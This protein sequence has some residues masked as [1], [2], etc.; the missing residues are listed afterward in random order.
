MRASC[1]DITDQLKTKCDQDGDDPIP[2]SPEP[3]CAVYVEG[4]SNLSAAFQL[5]TFHGTPVVIGP[6]DSVTNKTSLIPRIQLIAPVDLPQGTTWKNTFSKE[7]KW[8]AIECS[9]DPVVHS[10]RP[11]V[12]RGIYHQ[13]T[14][15]ISK[16]G[17]FEDSLHRPYYM[18]PP[19]GPEMGI[20]PNKDF[21]LTT[22]S[23]KAIQYFFMDFFAG[24]ARLDNFGFTF[25]PDNPEYKYATADLMQFI[26]LSNLTGCPGGTTKKMHCA[27]DNVAEAMS[28]AIRDT[29]PS[30]NLATTT[31]KAMSD[32]THISIHWQWII[33]PVLVWLLGLV[34]LLGT[35][36]KTRKAM[37]PT[38]KNETMPLLSLYR[39]GQNEKPLDDQVLETERVMLYQ[40]EGKMVLSG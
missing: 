27:M 39:D 8:Q 40:S 5:N 7:F 20:E 28:K 32:K 1:T 17:S 22:T 2:G 33:L 14:L 21:V 24:R 29:A 3:M 12:S 19:G 18:H 23:L 38:W 9:I 16:N 15:A 36:W 25:S 13:E 37:I 31:G 10:F 6:L 34:T 11:S 30:S 26:T 35:I 4:R